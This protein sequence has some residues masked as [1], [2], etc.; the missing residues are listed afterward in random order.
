MTVRRATADDAA[1]FAAIDAAADAGGWSAATYRD[2]LAEPACIGMIAGDAGF[3]LL[4]IAADTA[5]VLMV[6]VAPEHR[7]RGLARACL[8][9]ALAEAKARG[10]AKV[11]LEV[12]EPNTGARALYAGMGFAEAGRRRGYYTSGPHTGEDA[13]VLSCVLS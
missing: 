8:E 12:A 10:A 13:I 11:L 2:L 4:Q 5:D 7:R 3:A 6:A 1:L 9:A